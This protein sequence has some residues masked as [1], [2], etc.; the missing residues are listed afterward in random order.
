M[1]TTRHLLLGGNVVHASALLRQVRMLREAAAP[2]ALL[3][4]GTRFADDVR[5]PL[6]HLPCKSRSRTCCDTHN[7]RRGK[8]LS[9]P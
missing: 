9:S 1:D 4:V 6:P 2:L 3:Y 7:S 8:S 5:H